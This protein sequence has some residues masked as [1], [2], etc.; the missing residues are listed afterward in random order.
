[1][2]LKLRIVKSIKSNLVFQFLN[3][4]YQAALIPI[5]LYFWGVEKYGLWLI[6]LAVS[7]WFSLVDFGIGHYLPNKLTSLRK[8]EKLKSYNTIL[9]NFFLIH[10]ILVGVFF[11]LGIVLSIFLTKFNFLNYAD[12]SIGNEVLYSLMLL[13]FWQI[14]QSL[15]NFSGCIYASSNDYHM[16]QLRKNQ[17]VALNFVTIALGLFLGFGFIGISL[18]LM[19]NYIFIEMVSLLDIK[20]HYKFIQFRLVFCRYNLIRKIY[21]ES[22]W[23]MSIKVYD[24]GYQNIPILMLQEYFSTAM[25]VIF[26][27]HRTLANLLLQSK[28]II[29]NTVWRES[30]IL[31]SKKNILSVAKIYL[32]SQKVVVYFLIF[33]ITIVLFSGDFIFSIWLDGKV[34]FDFDMAVLMLII[35]VAQ[36]LWSGAENI[37]Y[38]WNKPFDIS[39]IKASYLAL[40]AI[41]TAIV[42]HFY[43]DI[44][45]MIA[46]NVF[47]NIAILDF[48]ILK[49]V[50]MNLKISNYFY[51]SRVLSRLLILSIPIV[52]IKFI[53]YSDLLYATILVMIVAFFIFDLYKY[54]SDNV[55][56]VLQDPND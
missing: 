45:Y 11:I 13:I 48:F 33:L 36:A 8:T 12:L 2:K 7:S 27:V 31:Y 20:K 19:V 21:K 56:V 32:F 44:Y 30:A 46:L 52:V 40:Y 29:Q 1:M 16:T 15:L 41:T 28:Q 43:H 42:L 55:G 54:E 35:A 50:H 47:L 51:F 3:V 34:A 14:F 4:G 10:I 49:K 39:I 22:V 24:V 6:L 23:F 38:S 9:G 17:N 25:V 53:P 26:S 5:F 37:S 18:I